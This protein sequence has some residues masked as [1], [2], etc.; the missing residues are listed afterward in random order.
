MGFFANLKTFVWS[1]HFLKQLGFIILAHIIIIGIVVFYLDFSTNHGEKLEVPSLVG[2]NIKSINGIMGE[3]ELKVEILDSVYFP[4][5]PTGTIVSQDPRPT[6]STDVYVKSSRI[7][8]V[9]LSKKTRLVEMPSLIDRSE[10][11]AESV[12]KNRGLKYKIIY[13]ATSESNGAVLDQKYKGKEILEGTRIPIGAT[14]T[15]TVGRN[16]AGVPVQIPNL[17]GLTI[18]EANERLMSVPSLKL[19][20]VYQDC[21]NA[22]DS[23]QARVVSQS[24]EYIEGVLSPSST[25][26][27]IQLS[28][29]G[30]SSQDPGGE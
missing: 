29:S 11:F 13:Q 16:E 22:A 3:S 7:I 21:L 14:I 6:D 15:L 25:T 10:R 26:V 1:K 8:R 24:P 4:K 17:F 28:K 27:T 20:L 12:L 19:F 30:A 18:N 2:K 5:L 23:S 9:R